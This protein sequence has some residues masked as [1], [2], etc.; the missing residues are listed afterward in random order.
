M[1]SSSFSTP[2]RYSSTCRRMSQFGF[3]S[4]N[5]DPWMRFWNNVMSASETG[6][7]VVSAMLP[8]AVTT[9]VP[10]LRIDAMA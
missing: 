9:T 5:S 8:S 2:L 4:P 6:S 7:G 10:A 3:D 1:S